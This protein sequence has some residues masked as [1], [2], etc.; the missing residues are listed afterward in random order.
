MHR[1]IGLNVAALHKTDISRALLG[2]MKKSAQES[3]AMYIC[4]IY[5]CRSGTS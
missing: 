2:Y 4:K 3:L 5:E 1:V